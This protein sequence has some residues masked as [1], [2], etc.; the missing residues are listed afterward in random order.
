MFGVN[1]PQALLLSKARQAT[2]ACW[3]LLGSVPCFQLAGAHLLLPTL[4][5]GMPWAQAL[6]AAQATTADLE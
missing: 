3:I 4:I 6:A 5:V 1:D 2:A